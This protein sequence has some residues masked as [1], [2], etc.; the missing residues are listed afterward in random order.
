MFAKLR[1]GKYQNS[2]SEGTGLLKMLTQNLMS[3]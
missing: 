3:Y 2:D 1:P